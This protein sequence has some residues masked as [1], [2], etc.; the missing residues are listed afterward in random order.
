MIVDTVKRVEYKGVALNVGSS[1]G[2]SYRGEYLS[3]IYDVVMVEKYLGYSVC[4]VCITIDGGTP[5]NFYT[6]L[7]KGVF[8]GCVYI[9]K[10]ENSG[11]SFNDNAM[12]VADS[13]GEHLHLF[14]FFPGG[15][16]ISVA[17]FSKRLKDLISKVNKNKYRPKRI[18]N[19][20]I[21]DSRVK[22]WVDPDYL[23]K[24]DVWFDSLQERREFEGSKREIVLK[25]DNQER[26]FRW[27]SYLAKNETATSKTQKALFVRDLTAS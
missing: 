6:R 3:L 13:K 2:R 12:G 9:L 8:N 26:V 7:F 5:T 15:G 4:H 17:S 22:D 1:G 19:F 20:N 21:V 16:S 10:R 25:P 14:V 23:E 11:G 18:R 27:V 24:Y